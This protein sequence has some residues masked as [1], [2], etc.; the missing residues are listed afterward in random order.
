MEALLCTLIG[1][2]LGCL[3]PA[4]LLSKIKKKDLRKEGTG[5]LGATNATLVLGKGCGALV[6]LFDITKAFAAARLAQRLFPA[7]IASGMIAGGAAVVGHIYPFYMK[8]KGGKGM[9]AFAGMILGTDPLMFIVLFA[10]SLVLML[11]LNYS[12]AM[13]SPPPCCFQYCTGSAREAVFAYY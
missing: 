1:Y 3:S 8:F 12:A 4:A 9:A 6:M 11:A 2:L 13:P 5:N 10:F 7:F